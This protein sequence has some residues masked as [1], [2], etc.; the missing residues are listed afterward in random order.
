MPGGKKG[1]G[2]AG[3]AA[4]ARAG[5]TSERKLLRTKLQTEGGV[6]R[7]DPGDRGSERATGRGGIDGIKKDG[8]IVNGRLVWR[9]PKVYMGIKARK[10]LCG[11]V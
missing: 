5:K 8:L 4:A 11:C 10:G 6:Q 2:V 7:E 1:G 3:G 9:N